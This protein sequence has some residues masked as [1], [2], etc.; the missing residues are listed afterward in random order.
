MKMNIIRMEMLIVKYK[1]LDTDK[2]V[3]VEILESEVNK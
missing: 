3:D 2:I 1:V